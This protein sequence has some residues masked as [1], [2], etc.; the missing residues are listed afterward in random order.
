MNPRMLRYAMVGGL[1]LALFAGGAFSDTLE[2]WDNRIFEG[3]I[4]TGIPD[5][6]RMDERGV[7]VTVKRAA[8]L[9]ITFTQGTEM[10]RLTT[11]TG[12]TFED[13]VLSAV[14][15]VTIRTDSGDTEVPNSQV[16]RITFP[17]QQTESPAY[18]ATAYMLDGRYYEG[19]LSGAFPQTIS[20]DVNGI[21]SNVR[22]DRV[23]SI[24][25]SPTARVE[26][27][28][29]VYEGRI[30]SNLPETI[31]LTTKYGEL[32]IKRADISRM[33]LAP[34]QTVSTTRTRVATT[35]SGFGIGA[36]S[37]DG[38]P[39]AFVHLGIGALSLEAGAGLTGGAIVFDGLLR[40]TLGL[41]GRTVSLFGAGGILGITGGGLTFTGME[42]LA[43]LE[44]SGAEFGLPISLFGGGAYLSVAGSGF[45]GYVAGIRWDF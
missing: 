14:G 37:L 11:T 23:I 27:Q 31:L 13:R 30:V 39:I 3:R 5:I 9:E 2:T 4:L 35:G 12:K 29:R 10:A 15:T 42:I 21:T 45:T 33:T 40:Y 6:V 26:T 17:Y 22:T 19:N 20:V 32:G 1:L 18:D 28:E 43:G 41:V 34:K 8:I 44:L 24:Q 36:K 7:S 38:I 25:F 16:R